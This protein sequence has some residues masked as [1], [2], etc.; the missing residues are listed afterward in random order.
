MYAK[1]LFT[2]GMLGIS[3]FLLAGCGKSTHSATPEVATHTADSG[4]ATGH[5]EGHVEGGWW[6]NEHGV[7]EEECAQCDSSLIA[8]FK[9]KGD[10][11]KE[12]D[13]PDS[14]CFICHPEKWEPYAALYEAKFGKRPNK[15]TADEEEHRADEAPPKS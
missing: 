1:H 9:A 13:R 15:P 14:H 5:A 10:W 7:P 4:G 2:I 6:C 8:A 3:S 11:C 12:H